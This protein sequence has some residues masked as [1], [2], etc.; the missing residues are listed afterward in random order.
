MTEGDQAAAVL[1]AA[2][3]R[4]NDRDIEAMTLEAVAEN[5]KYEDLDS[6][7]TE[8]SQSDAKAGAFGMEIVGAIVVPIL[9]EA[10]RQFWK[11]YSEKLIEKGGEELVDWTIDKFKD[12]FSNSSSNEQSELRDQLAEKILAVGKA[13]EMSE[14]DLDAI[15]NAMTPQKLTEA[16]ASGE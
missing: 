16:L 8:A 2:I 12:K 9:I 1:A 11:A 13:R 14:A 6:A 3:L 15:L 5:S 7:V 4:T 10:A